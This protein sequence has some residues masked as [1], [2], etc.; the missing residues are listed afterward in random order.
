[1]GGDFIFE[2]KNLFHFDKSTFR[3]SLSLSLSLSLSP[4]LPPLSH[5]LSNLIKVHARPSI[6][7]PPQRSVLLTTTAQCKTLL[8]QISGHSKLFGSPS[9]PST[10]PHLSNQPPFC[11]TT[12]FR[13]GKRWSAQAWFMPRGAS[14]FVIRNEL[15]EKWL[16]VRGLVLRL[17]GCYSKMRVRFRLEIAF[18]C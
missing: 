17:R 18:P 5:Y 2:K 12:I 14:Y 7:P 8:E 11:K 3:H 13:G 9:H 6:P 15:Q 10:V 16:A 1:M 4:S